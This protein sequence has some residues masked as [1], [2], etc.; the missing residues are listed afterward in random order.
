MNIVQELRRLNLPRNEYVVVGSGVLNPLGIRDSND[1]DLIVSQKIYDKLEE[2]GWQHDNWSDQIV[3]KKDV[4]DIGTNWYGLQLT[5]LLENAQ[6]VDGIPY[7][8]LDD[9]YE[10]KRRLGREKDFVDLE[11]IDLYR[12]SR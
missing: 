2:A 11:L 10:W 3:L 8:S 1:I 12:I 4:F 9:V 6:Y 5:Q 7:L